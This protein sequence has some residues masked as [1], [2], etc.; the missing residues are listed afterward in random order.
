MGCKNVDFLATWAERTNP[1][2]SKQITLH[3]GGGDFMYHKFLQTAWLDPEESNITEYQ[4]SKPNTLSQLSDA[5][6]F[7]FQKGTFLI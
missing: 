6:I 4:T 5:F 3:R 2:K 1:P 7:N